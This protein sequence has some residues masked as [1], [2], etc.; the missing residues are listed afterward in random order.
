[1]QIVR[2][3]N[4]AMHVADTGDRE[5]PAVVFVNSLGTDLRVWDPVL[6]LLPPGE[7]GHFGSK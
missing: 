5:G 2:I 4:L 6:P 3:D 1:M 7:L